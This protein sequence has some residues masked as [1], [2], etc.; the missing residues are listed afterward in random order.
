MIPLRYI[1]NVKDSIL[2]QR[3]EMIEQD[4]NLQNEVYYLKSTPLV[5]SVVEDMDLLVSYYVQEDKI[6][7][8]VTFSLKDLYT[9]APFMIVMDKEHVQPVDVLFYIKVLDEKSFT[10]FA[11]RS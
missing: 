3:N 8:E 2:W 10:I 9:E 6:P 5:Q 1:E 4:K 11:V 7:T